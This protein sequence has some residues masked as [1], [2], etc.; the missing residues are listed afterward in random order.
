MNASDARM[1]LDPAWLESQYNVRARV[2]EHPR[3]FARWEEASKLVRQSLPMQ[4]DLRYGSGPRAALDLFPPALPAG[5]QGAAP[6]APVLIFIHGGYW[7][8]L[9][10]D[11]FSFVA[12]AFTSRGVL[13]L[14]PRY[15]LCPQAS[16][17]Q[18]YLQLTQVVAWAWQQA[19][20][21]GGDPGRIALVGHSAGAHLAAMLLSCRWKDVD[22]AL[23]PAPLAGALAISGLYDLEPLRH[24]PSLRGDLNLSTHTVA[25]TSPAFFPRP[26]HG[27]LYAAVGLDESDE[28]LRQTRLIRE[29][30]GPSAVPVCETVPGKN[31]YT[32]LESL[33][34]P[35]GRLHDLALRLLGLR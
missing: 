23:P 19:A 15:P 14:V 33:V 1:Q 3:V 34:D 27:R 26:R 25:R 31:H 29:V 24:V 13:V 5:L 21:F 10:K 12:P 6:R 32:V 28:F 22:A 4:A 30:W 2:T 7:R 18:I 16:L 8:S 20:A 35:N 17:E 9:D 11:L